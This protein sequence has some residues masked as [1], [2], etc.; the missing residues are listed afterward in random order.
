MQA[1]HSGYSARDA[2]G[3]FN[4]LHQKVAKAALPANRPRRTKRERIRE[5]RELTM[6]SGQDWH[7]IRADHPDNHVELKLDLAH[8]IRTT[9]AASRLVERAGRII[10]SQRQ[11]GLGE[12]VEL[13]EDLIKFRVRL[14]AALNKLAMIE[15]R[16]GRGADF[17]WAHTNR[18][19]ALLKRLIQETSGYVAT[20]RQAEEGDVIGTTFRRDTFMRDSQPTPQRNGRQ[21]YHHLGNGPLSNVGLCLSGDEHGLIVDRFV[22]KDVWFTSHPNLWT[23]LHFWYGDPRDPTSKVPYEVHI[24]G[25]LTATEQE[26][27]VRMRSWRLAPEKLM[28]RVGPVHPTNI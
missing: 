26:N 8:A 19:I 12:P 28:Y 17:I 20:Q 11:I 1:L 18:Q 6:R 23:D 4:G 3:T 2:W 16:V 24:M 25:H 27:I 13:Y 21:W 14:L 15:G 22:M 7:I 10:D 5:Q 9:N